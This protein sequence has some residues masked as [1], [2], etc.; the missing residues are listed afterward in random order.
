M[1]YHQITPEERYTLATLRKQTP[2]LTTTEIARLLGRHR[3]TIYREIGR[4]STHPDGGYRP[5]RAQEAANGRRRRSRKHSQFTREQW[6][7][8]ESLLRADLSPEQV[9]GWLARHRL[10]RISH[11][12]VY[13]YVWRDKR[14]GGDLWRHLRQRPKYRKRYG[15]R[16]KRGR[17]AGKRH[18]TERP[19]A[20]ERRREIGHWEMDTVSGAG[21]T[22]CIATLVER[23]IG[24]VLI[25][26]LANHTKAE[27]NRRVIQLIRQQ[28]HLFKTI[29]VDNGT[30]F[31]GYEAIER[32]TGV[33]FYFA[34]P[35]HAWERGT[36][37]NTNG[38]I[39]QYLPKR[40]SMKTLTQA[41]CNQIAQILNN[42]PRKRHSFR[43]PVE[44][45]Q[46][47]LGRRVV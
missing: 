19:L 10:L 44:Q 8:I 34:T 38:L 26:K 43:T 9:S 16:E 13:Q 32:A 36:N 27:L 30:E 37:E 15:T 4:N 3:S 22:H 33:V 25:V 31:H 12:T 23:V 24:C 21:S 42:R 39:R 46:F 11:E 2:A 20:V 41:Q 28:R 17:L 29:T 45:L 5:F 47:C 1:R 14:R 7:M 40:Q 6:Q 35:Y 18:I